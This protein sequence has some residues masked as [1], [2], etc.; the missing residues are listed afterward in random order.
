MNIAY[1]KIITLIYII[2]RA[3][4]KIQE[5]LYTKSNSMKTKSSFF[6]YKHMHRDDTLLNKN[7]QKS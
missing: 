2:N 5:P 4:K 3:N 6:M 7:F 1:C